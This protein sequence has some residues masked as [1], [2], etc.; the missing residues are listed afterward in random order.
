MLLLLSIHSVIFLIPSPPPVS[1]RGWRPLPPLPWTIPGRST[2]AEQPLSCKGKSQ[3]C[4]G[5]QR[6]MTSRVPAG[7]SRGWA[8]VGHFVTDEAS[9]MKFT[10]LLSMLLFSHTNNNAMYVAYLEERYVTIVSTRK[11]MDTMQPMYGLVERK[12]SISRV[13]FV[14]ML[15]SDTSCWNQYD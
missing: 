5:W 14:G 3:L 11:K 8:A 4:Y 1:C 15:R 9:Y 6:W 2:G 7:Q 10:K 12:I 13:S